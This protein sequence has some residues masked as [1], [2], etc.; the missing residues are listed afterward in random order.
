VIIEI[1]TVLAISMQIARGYFLRI[2]RKFT[3]RLAADIWWL[4]FILLRDATIFVVVFLGF[5]LFWPGTFQDYPIAVPWQLLAID[6]YAFALVLLLV[7]DTDEDPKYNKLLTI[8]V[9]IG[10]F[11][12]LVGTVFVTESALALGTLPPTVSAS[13]SNIWGFFNTYFNSENNTALAIYS[14]YVTFTLLLLAGGIATM[15]SFRNGGNMAKKSMTL[16]PKPT[17]KQ[18]DAPNKP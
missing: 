14:F 2:L 11:L 15:S 8:F 16:Q 7:K 6:F 12:Y 18:P 1:L 4:L 13:T 5:T 3:L 9:L 17:V 10:T